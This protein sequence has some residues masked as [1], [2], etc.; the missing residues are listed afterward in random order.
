MYFEL[1]EIEHAKAL[2]DKK[3][4]IEELFAESALG[5]SDTTVASHSVWQK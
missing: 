4:T 5:L 1:L 3:R 2:P